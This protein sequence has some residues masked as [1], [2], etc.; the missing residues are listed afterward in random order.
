[1][2]KSTLLGIAIGGGALLLILTNLPQK[3]ENL[4]PPVEKIVIEENLIEESP[5]VIVEDEPPIPQ[6]V[7]EERSF[8]SPLSDDS[9]L[10]PDVDRMGQLFNPYPPLLPIVETVT[11]SGRVAWL[12]GR[13]AYLGDYASHYQTSKHFISRSLHG[14]GNYLSD[15]VSKGDR[16]NV[17]R[18]DKEVEFHLVLDLSRLKMWLYYF[19]KGEN[20]RVLLKAYPVCAGR[21]DPRSRSGSKTPLGTFSLGSEI[22]LYKPGDVRPYKKEAKE[23]ISIFGVRW[24]P[25]DREIAHCTGPCKGLGIHGAPLIPNG[26]GEYIENRGCI[27]NYESNGCIRLYTE[28]IEEIFALIVS[29][30]AYIHVVRD[31]TEAVLPGKESIPK[32]N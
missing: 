23:M 29:R 16:F 30:P 25:L 32:A 14:M 8:L 5:I 9:V 24:I 15:I 28:D 17:L 1:M 11:Y 10:P 20:Q 12:T 31:F 6:L 2:K 21:L 26:A 7:Q 22:A 13:A 19:D 27:G 18:N 3:K 4:A